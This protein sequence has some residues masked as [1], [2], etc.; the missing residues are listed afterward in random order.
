MKCK[1]GLL[2]MGILSSLFGL[3]ACKDSTPPGSSGKS[4][5]VEVTA[6]LNHLLM[7]LDRGERYEEPLHELL[8]QKGFGETTGGGT[9]MSQSREIE[10]IDVE[11]T[12]NDLTKGIPF[13]IEQLEAFGAPKGSVLRIGLQ[14]VGR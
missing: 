1:R 6:Q 7:P 10:Y 14:N 2:L 8:V 3:G 4:K 9:M 13:V 5:Q 12:L 11:I